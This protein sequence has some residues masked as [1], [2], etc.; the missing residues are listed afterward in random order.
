MNYKKLHEDTIAKLQ[1]AVNSGK[2]TVEEARGICADFIPESEDERI[3]KELLEHCKNQAKLYVQTGN[4]CPQIQSWIAWLEKQGEKDD[5]IL[6]LKDQI[7]SLH[8][9]IVAIK[10]T[11]RI[12]LE[13]QCEHA[14]FCDSI[15]VGDKVTRNQDGML[16]NLS[17]LERVAKSADKVNPKF[18]VGD[19]ITDGNITI[20]IEAIKNNC[21]LYCEDCTLYSTK[22]ADKVYHLWTIQDAKDGDILMANAPF[23][24]NGNLE[25]G[26][27]C[28][29]A[30]CAINTLGK[31]QIPKY[32]EHWTGHTT[33]PATKEQRELLFQKMKEA[34]YEWNAEKKELKKIE[35]KPAWSERDGLKKAMED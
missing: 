15:Q 3:R 11:H 4:K 27:G 12:E 1:E 18:K 2:I 30:H 19:W 6:I 32:P 10:E 34:G 21:Y 20:Q 9:A 29:G 24:F 13:K 28:P 17:Q 31:F 5:E 22:T 16:V 35:Q 26:I 23:I 33:T 14:K 8:A 25:G 7:E